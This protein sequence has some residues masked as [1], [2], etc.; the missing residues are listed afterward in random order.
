MHERGV[1]CWIRIAG[2]LALCGG[3]ACVPLP[4]QVAPAVAGK[5]V[6]ARSQEP[7][8]GAV[9]VVRFEGRY[10]ETLPDRELLGHREAYTDEH[11]RFQ[12]ARWLR[13][14][15]SAWPLFRSEARVVS[16]LRD[17]YR[18]A[19]PR[20]IGAGQPVQIA[21][22]P[23]LD[24]GGRQASCRPVAAERGEVAGYMQAWRD[25]HPELTP[26][27]PEPRDS[28]LERVLEARASLGFGENCEGPV[29]DLALSPQ[30][31][32]AA[33]AER[34]PGGSQVG[35]VEFSETGLADHRSLGL[36]EAVPPRRLAWSRAG[37][38]VLW[39]PASPD[40]RSASASIFA[41]QR[42]EAFWRP[43][44]GPS[45]PASPAP[46]LGLA[47]A[48]AVGA[49]S[50]V[51]RVPLDPEDLND[52]GDARWRGRSFQLSRALAGDTGLPVDVLTVVREDGSRARIALPGEVCGARGRFGRPH[53]RI[54]ADGATGL[55]LRFVNGGCHVVG[56]DLESGVW[57]Q[58]DAASQPAVCRSQ[59]RLPATHLRAAMRGYVREIES[60]VVA[61]GADPK[62]AYVLQLSD[63]GAAR[64]ETRGFDGRLRTVS[65]PDFP[66][67]T[68]L[69]RIHV[70]VL[71]SA[72]RGPEGAPAISG[73]QP[74]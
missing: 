10:D 7:L 48:R 58:L 2:V 18:C 8:A 15:F 14:G 50:G 42:I 9:V 71:G 55:D 40:D 62:A 54:A 13:P 26:Q 45:L 3:A 6:D 28:D 37:D 53:F 1:R 5:V 43:E 74:L 35:V 19:E 73:P 47:P 46:D 49:A 41:P 60:A 69:R 52:E 4:V 27:G 31:W 29:A 20:Q 44:P 59:R 24:A 63:T 21:L 64:A 11:G 32:R 30:G 34:A 51:R 23:A 65:L 68:P 70:S 57:A 61:A 56:M 38:L 67:A 72:V 22:E 16:V 36:A 25:L 33:W 17:G 66:V 12:I 39:E